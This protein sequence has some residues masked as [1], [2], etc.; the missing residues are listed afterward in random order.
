VAEKDAAVARKRCQAYEAALENAQNE[1]KVADAAAA[2]SHG[3]KADDER[4]RAEITT[5]DVTIEELM[6][7]SRQLAEAVERQEKE[8]RAILDRTTA[9]QAATIEELNERS[10]EVAAL[11]RQL[12]LTKD[13]SSSVSSDMLVS[14]VAVAFDLGHAAAD[15]ML[16][17]AVTPLENVTEV[18][19]ALGDALA[20]A[21]CLRDEASELHQR[22]LTRDARIQ[23]L[24]AIQR[25]T[26]ERLADAETAAACAERRAR[27]LE[28]L[29]P[30]LAELQALLAQ[31][32]DQLHLKNSEY[33]TVTSRLL[34]EQR[35]WQNKTKSSASLIRELQA[36]LQARQAQPGVSQEPGASATAVMPTIVAETEAVVDEARV[37][38]DR[39]ASLQ[40]KVWLLEAAKQSYE[41]A[42][43]GLAKDCD[44]KR[45]IIELHFVD[46]A[47][48]AAQQR[49][50][51]G[52]LFG[53]SSSDVQMQMQHMVEATL[54]RN[55]ELESE[56][57]LLQ[58]H[59]QRLESLLAMAA[60]EGFDM[61][62]YD[63]SDCPAVEDVDHFAS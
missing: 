41:T 13:P 46:A 4:L 61:T 52:S 10:A 9:A 55:L 49:G 6:K 27:E 29:A 16:R 12:I 51:L 5:R 30:Q 15:V 33:E 53:P 40:E 17:K 47:H 43:D 37:L 28:P 42:M 3:H 60:E 63:S 23:E 58:R 18:C 1:L 35:Q 21:A 36:Q 32:E 26:S 24:S 57:G 59:V 31:V 50:R 45:R 25:Q 20:A 14:A 2:D 48:K 54:T 11:K 34:D 38:L 56:C 39:V 19:A 22:L 7:R 62:L 8:F 44:A